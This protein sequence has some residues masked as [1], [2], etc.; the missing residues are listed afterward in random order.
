MTLEMYRDPKK[1]VE[2]ISALG[3]RHVG[4]GIPTEFFAPFVS[5]AVE[6]VRALNADETAEEAFRFSLS[7]VSRILVRTI[8][9]G[10]TIVM[11][12]INTNSEKQLNKAVACAPRGKRALWM[13]NVTVG[14]QSISPLYWAIESG[15]LATA[16]AMIVD[17][18]IIRADRDNYYYGCDALFERHT[19]LVLRLCQGAQTL[20]EPLFDGLIWRSRVA[21]S[22]TRRVN[23]YVKHLV[24]DTHKNLSPVLEWIVEAQDTKIICHPV[25]VLFSDLLWNGLA[26]RYFLAGRLY[27][28]FTLMIFI[29]SQ[30]ILQHLHEGQE[31]KAERIAT[32]TLRVFIYLF[33]MGQI[34]I[35][36]MLKLC[37]DLRRQNFK[38]CFG[39]VPVPAFIFKVKDAVSCALLLCL[40]IMLSNEPIFYCMSTNDGTRRLA[41]A[42]ASTAGSAQGSPASALSLGL[43]NQNCE[44]GRSHKQVYSTVSMVAMLFYWAL[45]I[46]LSVFSV[47]ISAFVQVCGRVVS[48]V[49]LFLGALAFLVL[50]FSSSISALNHKN[51]DFAGIPKGALSLLEMALGMFPSSHY[52]TMQEEPIVLIVVCMFTIITL[53]FLLNL[54]VAQLNG[55]YQAV[56]NDMLGYARLSRGKITAE[57]L[58]NVGEGAWTKFL[59]SLRF[60]DRLEFNEGDIGLAGGIQ[61]AEPSNANPTTVDAIRRFGGS[62]SPTVQWPEEANSNGDDEDKFERLEKVLLKVSKSGGG[63]KKSNAGSSMGQ[64]SMSGGGSVTSSE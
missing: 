21:V 4:Y 54:L 48:E 25:V 53:V 55:A 20:L 22:G 11:K 52:E 44:E 7:L 38:R 16:R 49:F 42:S 50:S 18:L 23:Y 43:F 19:D 61:V 26:N 10:S 13:L 37:K 46:D 2:D 27:F 62:T 17:L 32:A 14:T 15:S 35:I 34:F 39:Y 59:T 36:Q 57:T 31:S 33:S 30:S 9:E 45:L 1:M 58:A 60:E 47:R 3:L 51:K 56:Y 40:I 41:A 24:Q 12:A 63:K 6:V 28:V 5:G 64:S 29:T 8:N